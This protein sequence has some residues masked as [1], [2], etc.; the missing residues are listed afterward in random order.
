MGINE[1]IAF[2][3]IGFLFA[4]NTYQII[5][6]KKYLTMSLSF[7]VKKGFALFGPP[8]FQEEE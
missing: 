6:K 3:W 7:M 1:C 8:Q 2:G 5:V 4:I